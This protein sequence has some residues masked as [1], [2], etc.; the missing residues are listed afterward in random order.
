MLLDIASANLPASKTVATFRYRARYPV[1]V[2]RW[3][4]FAGNWGDQGGDNTNGEAWAT[5]EDGRVC[6]SAEIT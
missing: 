5:D 3:L 4:T 2:N 6:M 1:I